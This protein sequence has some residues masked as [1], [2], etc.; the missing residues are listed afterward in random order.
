[1]FIAIFAGDN[2]QLLHMAREF[3]QIKRNHMAALLCFDHALCSPPWMQKDNAQTISKHLE[4]YDSYAQLMRQVI[5]GREKAQTA[6]LLG[7]IETGGESA[8]EGLQEYEVL[9]TS[10]LYENLRYVDTSIQP[11]DE[12]VVVNIR[13]LSD[14]IRDVLGQRLMQR[15]VMQHE[16]CNR[17]KAFRLCLKMAVTGQCNRLDCPYGHV[18]RESLDVQ[19]F[20]QHVRLH[21][22]QVL[23]VH[24]MDIVPHNTNRRWMHR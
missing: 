20:N 22:Q 17:T 14:A 10:I 11:S 1:M 16:L 2:T 6:K 24:N 23:I 7:F 15:L 18:P 4:D 3:H 5:F 13:R 19:A 12:V 9:P 8:M 21:L